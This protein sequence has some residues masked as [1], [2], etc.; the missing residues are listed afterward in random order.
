[1]GNT[2]FAGEA[3]YADRVGDRDLEWSYALAVTAGQKVHDPITGRVW[4]A[5]SD[6]TAPSSGTMLGYVEANPSLWEEYLGVP[7]SLD[8][9]LPWSDMREP[10]RVKTVRT[11]KIATKG[12][13]RFT[14]SVF[15]DGLYKDELGNVIH[16][17]ALSEEFVGADQQGFGASPDQHYGGGRNSQDPRLYKFP[18][19][20]KRAK[21]RVTATVREKISFSYFSFMHHRGMMHRP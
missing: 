15:V 5:L 7:I 8:W 17:P 4:T 19:R 21:I 18:V 2:T 11:I 16:S 13:A 1:M 10:E 9:E 14:V 12:T 6:L 20:F 3:V